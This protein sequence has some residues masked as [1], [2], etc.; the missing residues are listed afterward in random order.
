MMHRPHL[1]WLPQPTQEI[2]DIQ[3]LMHEPWRS[4]QDKAAFT[5]THFIYM[6]HGY[7]NGAT[8]VQVERKRND[9]AGAWSQLNT[10]K[11]EDL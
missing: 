2:I 11:S 1:L 5:N 3:W 4:A 10:D 9:T 7:N 8:R 6:F